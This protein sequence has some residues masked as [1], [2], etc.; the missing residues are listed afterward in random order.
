LGYERGKNFERK[1]QERLAAIRKEFWQKA[2]ALPQTEKDA[3]VAEIAK[4]RKTD[5]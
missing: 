2:D 3:L 1:E 4:A 5:A